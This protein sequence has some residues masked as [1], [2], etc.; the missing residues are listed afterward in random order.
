MMI[1][2]LVVD[3]EPLSRDRIVTLLQSI[4]EAEVV[5]ECETGSAAIRAIRELTPDLLFLDVQMPEVDGFGVLAAIPS[6]IAPAVIFVTAYDQYAIRAFEVH[7]QDYLLKPFDPDRFYAAFN[8]VAQRMRDARSNG[9]SEKLA[10]LLEDIERDRP[11][12]TRLPIR[13]GGRVTFLPLDQIDWLE[14]ADNYVRIHANGDVHVVRQT[15]QHM[16]E[17][18]PSATFV[19]I[20]RSA[21]INVEHIREIQPWF[22][23]EY[24]VQLHSGA[25]VH[26]SRRYRARLEALME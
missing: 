16:E 23:G 3:D 21:I 9:T 13:S 18:L 12:R 24:V 19:R 17:S 15:L 25:A 10:A 4:P 1:R 5:G 11:R 2:C 7:A 20:H 8:H 26:T 6:Q 22:G 14:A